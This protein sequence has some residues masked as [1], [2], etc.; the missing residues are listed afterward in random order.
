MYQW[1]VLY[2]YDGSEGHDF[3][4]PP[5]THTQW[6]LCMVS[7]FHENCSVASPCNAHRD[8]THFKNPQI[9]RQT[10]V[11]LWS[12]DLF[13]CEFPLLHIFIFY[14]FTWKKK[15]KVASSFL[16]CAHL[17]MNSGEFHTGKLKVKACSHDNLVSCRSRLFCA[18]IWQNMA[19][20]EDTL[21][22][23][24]LDFAFLSKQNVFIKLSLALISSANPFL[25]AI[26]CGSK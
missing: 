22:V 21:H 2:V 14:F 8:L 12:C 26:L 13:Y 15:R 3:N 25:E 1:T 6:W 24:H 18:L 16:P 10:S 9:H 19:S 23:C 5:P 7:H 11:F 4:C 20:I 17:I